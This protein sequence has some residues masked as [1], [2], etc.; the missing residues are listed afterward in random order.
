MLG[1]EVTKNSKT[2]KDFKDQREPVSIQNTLQVSFVY[3]IVLCI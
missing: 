2:L 1:T 3:I